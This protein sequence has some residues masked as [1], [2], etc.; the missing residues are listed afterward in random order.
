MQKPVTIR[1]EVRR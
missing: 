1:E